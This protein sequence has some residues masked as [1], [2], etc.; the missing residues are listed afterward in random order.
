MTEVASAKRAFLAV[1][2]EGEVEEL[3]FV[4]TDRV[5][6]LSSFSLYDSREKPTLLCRFDSAVIST[7]D[8][9][10]YPPIGARLRSWDALS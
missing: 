4:R 6:T 1:F 3:E 7:G 2:T 9:G 8:T 10:S 5:V